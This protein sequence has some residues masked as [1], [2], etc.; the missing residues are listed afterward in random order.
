LICRNPAQPATARGQKAG[1]SKPAAHAQAKVKSVFANKLGLSSKSPFNP[2]R[3]VAGVE[4]WLNTLAM[5]VTDAA[6]K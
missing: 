3:S 2:V 5:F 4:R 6:K 1:N